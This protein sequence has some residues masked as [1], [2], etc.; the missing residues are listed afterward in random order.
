MPVGQRHDVAQRPAVER[1]RPVVG[2]A[3]PTKAGSVASSAAKSCRA[4][5]VELGRADTATSHSERGRAIADPGTARRRS[6]SSAARGSTGIGCGSSALTRNTNQAGRLTTPIRPSVEPI[7]ELRDRPEV[8]DDLRDPALPEAPGARSLRRGPPGVARGSTARSDATS[9]SSAAAWW[10][11]SWTSD[12]AIPWPTIRSR[13]TR[14]IGHRVLPAAGQARARAPDR[15]ARP[16]RE[17][18]DDLRLLEVRAGQAERVR[19]QH[20]EAREPDAGVVLAALRDQLGEQVEL[21][22][23]RR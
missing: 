23:R 17:V 7:A 15:G 10:P 19:R 6:R 2:R 20:V 14:T 21:R 5:G 11:T 16:A 9:S 1:A 3:G 18:A 13:G 22:Q 8:G 4:S 12:D